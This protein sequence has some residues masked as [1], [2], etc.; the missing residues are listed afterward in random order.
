MT[1]FAANPPS[2]QLTP[3]VEGP[4]YPLLLSICCVPAYHPYLLPARLNRLREYPPISCLSA[5]LCFPAYIYNYK[6]I[7]NHHFSVYF[8][9]FTLLG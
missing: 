8:V 9:C 7:Y 6:G 5:V 4:A 2:S 1:E 3:L